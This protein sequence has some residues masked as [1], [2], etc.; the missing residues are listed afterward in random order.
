MDMVLDVLKSKIDPA[1]TEELSE[2]SA[3]L[4]LPVEKILESILE[5]SSYSLS[6][7]H[8]MTKERLEMVTSSPALLSELKRLIWK[9]RWS[10]QRQEYA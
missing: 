8:R 6:S 2:L 1:A 10:G 9:E 3:M 5:K 4:A 7:L